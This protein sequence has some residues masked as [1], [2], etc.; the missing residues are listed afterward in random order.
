[1]LYLSSLFLAGDQYEMHV[2]A[3]PSCMG[4]SGNDVYSNAQSQ[5]KYAS[6]AVL[7]NH[8]IN[9]V[10]FK[11]PTYCFILRFLSLPTPICHS[12]FFSIPPFIQQE[13]NSIDTLC[14]YDCGAPIHATEL[15]FF[16]EKKTRPWNSLVFMYFILFLCYECR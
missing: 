3:H 7:A 6:N 2:L 10:S 14:F 8:V 11:N 12:L 15:F 9:Q 4:S 16:L 13:V 1:M 5:L